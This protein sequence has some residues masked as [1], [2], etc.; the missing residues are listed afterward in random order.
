MK[1]KIYDMEYDVVLEAY[2]Q[3]HNMSLQVS[4]YVDNGLPA[5]SGVC[6]DATPYGALTVNLGKTFETF[7][8]YVTTVKDEYY[9]QLLEQNIVFR[10]IIE[11]PY[12]FNCKAHLCKINMD[13]FQE[14]TIK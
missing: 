3:R 14:I 11:I 5:I 9:E 7:G 13:K 2:G 4:R 10:E 8:D 1:N 6:E 12:G